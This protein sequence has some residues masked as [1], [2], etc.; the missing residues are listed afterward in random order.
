MKEAPFRRLVPALLFVALASSLLAHE[1]A[2]GPVGFRAEIVTELTRVE[3]KI[4]D[5]AQ[6]MPQEKFGWRPAE[7]VRSAGEIYLHI[8]GANFMV[9]SFVGAKPPAGIDP[10]S[11]EKSVTE[12]AK[13]IDMVKRSFDHVRKT[14][15]NTPDA[16]MEKKV[17]MFGQDTNIR[18]VFVLLMNHA[19]EHLGQSIAYARVN[20]VSPPW[21][22]AEEKPEPKKAKS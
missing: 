7:G 15:Q 13:V 19:H 4:V 18:S 5:L 20:G 11:L 2:A 6:A 1:P 16:D 8:A 9:T 22:V 21:S 17:K 3:K 12:K 14:V 10:T